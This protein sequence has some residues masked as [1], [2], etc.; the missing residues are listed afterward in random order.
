MYDS[1]EYELYKV[2]YPIVFF[3]LWI[4][5]VFI[6]GGG[7]DWAVIFGRGLGVRDGELSYLVLLRFQI[8]VSDYPV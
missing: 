1:P 6:N 5:S 4:V 3:C 8:L 2:I 7:K